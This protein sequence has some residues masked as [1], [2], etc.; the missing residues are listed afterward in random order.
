MAKIFE[1]Y[2]MELQT[3]MV[4]IC[5]E[6]AENNQ[7]GHIDMLFI[8]CHLGGLTGGRYWY[9]VEKKILSP[10]KMKNVD[11]RYDVSISRQEQVQRIILDD[12]VKIKNLCKEYNQP[13]PAE[14]KLVY[15]ARNNSFKGQ[16]VY[17]WKE[18]QIGDMPEW[19]IWLEELKEKY[20]KP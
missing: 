9:L 15:N 12:L 20:E 19:E 11:N 8:H 10:V 7:Y 2:W 17:D 13:L 14:M 16:Y 1:D 5:M 3:D 6:F 4:E 18:T